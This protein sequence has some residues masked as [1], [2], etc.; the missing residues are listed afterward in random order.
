[1]ETEK[2][3]DRSQL[4]LLPGIN[5][6][7]DEEWAMMEPHLAA[8]IAGGIIT[9]LERKEKS[10]YGEAEKRPAK[11]LSEFPAA[12]AEDLVKQCVNPDT[13]R[14]WYNEEDR[15]SVRVHIVKRMEKLKV[16]IPDE[17]PVKPADDDEAEDAEEAEEPEKTPAR[18]K[19][20]AGKTVP[21][22]SDED[23]ALA[24]DLS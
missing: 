11:R 3:P 20:G 24:D 6:V 19:R 12:F 18:R 21:A 2:K 7:S 5:E 23:M 15:G 10:A 1:M 8:E 14:K 22:K 13:L 16:A 9:I 17:T 4:Q